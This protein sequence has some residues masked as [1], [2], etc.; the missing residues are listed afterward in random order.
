MVTK[1]DVIKYYE[2][3]D[4]EYNLV[5][6][7]E[8]DLAIHYGFW[9]PHIKKHSD[10]LV[11]MNRVLAKRVKIRPDDVVLD[12]GCGIGG[13]SIWIAKN[14]GARVIGITISQKQVDNAK[15]LAEENGVGDRVEF[16]KRDYLDT[17]F[18]KNSF[19]VVWGLESVCHAKNKGDFIRE[20]WR[21]LKPGGRL[22]VADGFMKKEKL[23]PE[24][25]RLVGKLLGGWYVPE[26]AGISKFSGYLKGMKF[27]DIRF[28]DVTNNVMPS[29]KRIY[30]LSV[31]GI[32]LW[33]LMRFFGIKSEMQVNHLV[34]GI[35]QYKALRK[36]L[37][38][39]GIF[40][41]E[42]R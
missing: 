4:S 7:G 29:S 36:G 21:I 30:R 25:N 2:E 13:S 32:G 14:I 12:A 11:N 28:S 17:K 22:V 6:T 1:E 39:Y 19:D 18:E 5:W 9:E 8:R 24:E 40:S 37:C 35:C 33:K 42:K 23:D 27:R 38:V 34:A 10:A 20:A 41:A 26:L 16:L 31:C 3:C 15:K